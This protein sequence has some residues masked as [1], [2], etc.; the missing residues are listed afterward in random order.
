VLPIHI[1]AQNAAI[2]LR[3]PIND[4]AIFTLE[5]FEVLTPPK[6]VTHT[7]GKLR[8]TYPSVGRLSAPATS[9]VHKA[10]AEF[11]AYYAQSV[12][13][14]AKSQKVVKR[15]STEDPPT[16]RYITELLTGIIRGM[17]P[18]PDQ[19][20]HQ[21]TFIT[22][23]IND[24]ALCDKE[25]HAPW[26]RSPI[27]LI[28]RVTLQ[29]TLHDLNLDERFSYKSFMVYVISSI[30]GTALHFKQPDYLLFVMNA[31]LARRVWK[32]SHANITRDGLFA[33]DTAFDINTT[34][35][36][37]LGKRWKRIQ[38]K[39]TRK[40]DWEV[41][42]GQELLVAAR[43]DLSRSLQYLKKAKK[44]K[45]GQVGSKEW[46]VP[47]GEN[48]ATRPGRVFG[49]I[50]GP[51][52]PSTLSKISPAPL[53][54]MIQ[55]YDFECWVAD[56]LPAIDLPQIH[57]VKLNKALN[58]YIDVSLAHYKGN[59]ERLSVAFLTILEL[60]M[61]IDRKV[62]D[63]M[64][65]LKR[66][67]PEIPVTVL[68]PLL[69]PYRSQ[70]ERHAQVEIY[71]EQRQREGGRNSAVFYDTKDR[72]SFVSW[73]VGQ[74]AP[75][76]YTLQNMEREA[77]K[78]THQKEVEMEH[79]NAK[80]RSLT[81]AMNAASCTKTKVVERNKT[82]TKHPSCPKCL[83]KKELNRMQYACPLFFFSNWLIVVSLDL[84]CSSVLCQP[85]ILRADV[86]SLSSKLHT[87]SRSGEMRHTRFFRPVREGSRKRRMEFHG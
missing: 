36:D 81:Q 17:S 12:M 46:V 15:A 13:A 24:H 25:A 5:S 11:I 7:E 77:E 30:L 72:D 28:L 59:P 82:V 66:Y 51:E 34:V 22:K 58:D 49:R 6:I 41:P 69:L 64:P 23:R 47:G 62:I 48:Y 87:S 83:K 78:E 37:E 18:N 19:S 61:F 40:I 31:K 56:E 71:L 67:S 45:Q 8:I 4:P 75:L 85:T 84:P 14:D 86:L 26:R 39:T 21:T 3:R 65:I 42:T 70:M 52:I 1:A 55:L 29:T 9:A 32:L 79:M 35:S 43:M 73:F 80:Y 2:I 57:M 38:R 68:E 50:T 10:L 74:S 54:R 27:W 33:M 53:E 44:L 63:W 76:Q 20:F 60:W 16:P